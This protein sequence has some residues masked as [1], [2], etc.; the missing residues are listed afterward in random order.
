M[1]GQLAKFEEVENEKSNLQNTVQNLEAEIALLRESNSGSQ[2]AQLQAS[3]DLQSKLKESNAK[4]NRLKS[5]LSQAEELGVGSLV[6]IEDELAAVK[7]ENDELKE[8]FNPIL[9]QIKLR[10]KLCKM[11]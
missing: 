7:N 1:S 2:V 6:D 11:S 8:H 10:L 9:L 5:Q 4:I 3:A